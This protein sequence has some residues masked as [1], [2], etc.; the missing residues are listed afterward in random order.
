MHFDI[1]MLDLWKNILRSRA[2]LMEAYDLPLPIAETQQVQ[3]ALGK[4]NVYEPGALSFMVVDLC[5]LNHLDAVL[6]SI[7]EETIK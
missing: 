5:S 3:L 7:R 2:A 1:T 4:V 6:S